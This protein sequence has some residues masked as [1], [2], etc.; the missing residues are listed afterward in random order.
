[1]TRE[2]SYFNYY[3]LDRLKPLGDELSIAYNDDGYIRKVQYHFCL[4]AKIKNKYCY[5]FYKDDNYEEFIYASVD[6]IDENYENLMLNVQNKLELFDFIKTIKTMT[7][8]EFTSLLTF[9]Y[10][11]SDFKDLIDYNWD[12]LNMDK[13]IEI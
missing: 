5:V 11:Y 2:Q 3:C 7:I 10:I 1:M 13:L 12:A 8:F 6:Y 9:T 4:K